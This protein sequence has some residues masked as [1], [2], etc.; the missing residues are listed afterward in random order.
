MKTIL[1]SVTKLTALALLA[2]GMSSAAFAYPQTITLLPGSSVTITPGIQTTVTCEG[3]GSQNGVRT[4]CT[5]GPNQASTIAYDLIL[6]SINS[7]GDVKSTPLASFGNSSYANNNKT[8][9]EGAL[10]ANGLCK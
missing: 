6:I 3:Q 9:C 5:C 2:F 1:N 8:E 10:A 7:Q 4:S